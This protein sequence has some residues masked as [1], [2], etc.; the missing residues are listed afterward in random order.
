MANKY[1]A[2]Q[3][4]IENPHD[5]DV[6]CGRG[7]AAFK[8]V[9]NYTFRYLVQLNKPI[10]V[11][12]KKSQ[13]RTISK[14]I[15][16]AIKNQKPPGR[17]LEL[18]N[19]DGLW[20]EITDSRTIEKTSQALREG[21][22][23]ILKKMGE[24]DKKGEEQLQQ[25]QL[26]SS[27]PVESSSPS[28][29]DLLQQYY[30]SSNIGASPPSAMLQQEVQ[31][32]SIEYEHNS[33]HVISLNESDLNL[34]Q[35]HLHTQSN[36]ATSN[37]T[38]FLRQQQQQT[39]VPTSTGFV[40][41]IP[42]ATTLVSPP[43]PNNVGSYNTSNDFQFQEPQ[44]QIPHQQQ[45]YNYNND[46]QQEIK[47]QEVTDKLKHSLTCPKRSS[48]ASAFSDMDDDIDLPANLS[49]VWDDNMEDDLRISD[50]NIFPPGAINV[51]IP[52][53]DETTMLRARRLSS[54][55]TRSTNGSSSSTPSVNNFITPNKNVNT[56]DKTM[57]PYQKQ[58]S[59][60]TNEEEDH[61]I[62]ACSLLG[63]TSSKPSQSYSILPIK[64]G[65]KKGSGD[66]GMDKTGSAVSVL[67]DFSSMSI[68][69]T[70][71]RCLS[72]DNSDKN[73]SVRFSQLSLMDTDDIDDFLDIYNTHKQSQNQQ[74]Q[75][76]QQSPQSSTN[77]PTDNP[78]LNYIYN[79]L[80]ESN[81]MNDNVS[82]SL[83]SSN[84]RN[85]IVF[86]EFIRDEVAKLAEHDE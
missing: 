21:Q 10:Y 64:E 11:T 50:K 48:V 52:I 61:I 56:S 8:H 22:A 79:M 67:S 39:Y 42:E 6:L 15:V 62:R 28:P 63:S 36:E 31:Q 82:D 9:G 17:F 83:N 71:D 12:C 70:A 59:D 49:D 84:K 46:E 51:N 77:Y 55:L 60:L 4:G 75:Q 86:P 43:I 13:K 19:K 41:I 37:F 66:F 85:G 1:I 47:Q 38:T 23:T 45:N 18:N 16:T 33:A 35:H 76:Q 58:C 24:G 7:G 40:P 44:Q 3:P 14:N 68:T 74:Q 29:P 27:L 81:Q 73:S 5:H 34:H 69:S 80:N 26:S 25:E 53:I 32:E 54:Y 78:R 65:G 30:V 20:Y 57:E 72:R 2:N